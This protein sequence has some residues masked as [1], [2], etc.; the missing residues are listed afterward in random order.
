MGKK[1][2]LRVIVAVFVTKW[3]WS[4]YDLVEKEVDFNAEWNPYTLLHIQ[5]EGQFGTKDIRDA[6]KR[7]SKKY[8]PDKVD[9]SKLGG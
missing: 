4:V 9:W 3:T 8:H 2:Y 6:Y 7:L 1:L 5:D